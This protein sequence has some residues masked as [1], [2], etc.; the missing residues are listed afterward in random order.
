MRGLRDGSIPQTH[1]DR[2]RLLKGALSIGG[3]GVITLSAA[4][5]VLAAEALAELQM[6]RSEAKLADPSVTK[7]GY[8]SAETYTGKEG[9]SG[10]LGWGVDLVNPLADLM[11][12]PEASSLLVNMFSEPTP[13]AFTAEQIQERMEQ[14]R[15]QKHEQ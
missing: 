3:L 2:N 6:E 1:E 4:D 5:Q 14:L 15:Q 7:F 8:L 9:A 11:L 12:I 10:W 13:G